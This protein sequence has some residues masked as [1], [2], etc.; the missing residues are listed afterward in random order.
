MQSTAKNV[1]EYL[2]EVPV[3]RASAVAKLRDLCRTSLTGFEE[4]MIYSMPSYARNGEVEVAFA[5]QKN[6]IAVYILRTD[7]M[8]AHRGLLKVKGVNL[9]KGCIRYAKPENIDFQ[10]VEMMLNATQKST[11]VVC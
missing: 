1:T 9:G 4:S 5:S 3:D 6:Y 8:D 7:I 10:V 2:D 11:G